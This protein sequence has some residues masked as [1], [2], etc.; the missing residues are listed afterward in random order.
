MLLRRQFSSAKAMYMEHP[1][2]IEPIS[3]G[4]IG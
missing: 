4:L 3:H 2:R 1:V